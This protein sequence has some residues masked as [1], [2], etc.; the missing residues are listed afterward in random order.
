M[1]KDTISSIPTSS[2]Q[3]EFTLYFTLISVRGLLLNSIIIRSSTVWY[4]LS[5]GK[6]FR[7][8]SLLLR[9]YITSYRI[10][11]AFLLLLHLFIRKLLLLESSIL[12]LLIWLNGPTSH[13]ILLAIGTWIKLS[14]LLLLLQF[15]RIMLKSAFISHIAKTLQIMSTVCRLF[16]I[17][18][19]L[20]WV[21]L[22]L[23]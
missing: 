8:V 2:R 3:I 16:P 10:W 17:T 1:Q 19:L 11:H 9:L 20:W 15:N 23:L 7:R 21:R 12:I 6:I 22:C 5:L 18:S 13:K 4:L 14:V